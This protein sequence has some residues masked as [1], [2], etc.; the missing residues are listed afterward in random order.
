MP[1][2]SSN[3]RAVLL[4]LSTTRVF[5][6]CR[7]SLSSKS[8]NFLGPRHHWLLLKGKGGMTR[9]GSATGLAASPHQ[10]TGCQSLQRVCR[11][12]L[13][14]RSPFLFSSRA[15]PKRNYWLCAFTTLMGGH[16]SLGATFLGSWGD[17]LWR[18]DS[19]RIHASPPTLWVD[20]PP[21]RRSALVCPK[22]GRLRSSSPGHFLGS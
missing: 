12:L 20:Y 10:S 6:L 16:H 21:N 22:L 11:P 3:C 1:F 2:Y 5:E 9:A 17:W 18:L 14:Q 15:A 4:I 19:P 13:R 8:P 7:S